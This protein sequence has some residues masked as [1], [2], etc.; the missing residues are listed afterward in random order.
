MMNASKGSENR[1]MLTGIWKYLYAL[2]N[3]KVLG[4]KIY[5]FKSTIHYEFSV[6]RGAISCNP[7]FKRILK[8]LGLF[9]F[10]KMIYKCFLFLEF[11][12]TCF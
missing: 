1:F 4:V 5:L 3:N 2:V 10:I 12:H 6:I 9:V 8:N 11:L 7:K